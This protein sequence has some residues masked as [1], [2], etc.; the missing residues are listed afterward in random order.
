MSHISEVS[1]DY[2]QI[3]SNRKGSFFTLYIHRQKKFDLSKEAK[4]IKSEIK[5]P[6]FS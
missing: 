5:R 6:Y 4:I 3:K 1:A 2:K